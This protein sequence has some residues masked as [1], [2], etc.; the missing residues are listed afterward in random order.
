LRFY[1]KELMDFV[2]MMEN[3][4]E[5][6][7]IDHLFDHSQSQSHAHRHSSKAAA[8]P[9]V[10]I[11]WLDVCAEEPGLSRLCLAPR[12]VFEL[13]KEC[14]DE[15]L[16]VGVFVSDIAEVR[17]GASSHAFRRYTGRKSSPK[18]LKKFFTGALFRPDQCLA[19]VGSERSLSLQFA[20]APTDNHYRSARPFQSSGE[21]DRN[22]EREGV[23]T[24]GNVMDRSLFIDMLSLLVLQSLSPF[25][26]ALRNGLVRRPFR[27]VCPHPSVRPRYES[28]RARLNERVCREG[29]KVRQL[30]LTGIEVDEE[31]FSPALGALQI[32]HKRLQYLPDKRKLWIRCNDSLSPPLPLSPPPPVKSVSA[33]VTVS[34]QDLEE[35]TSFSDLSP[36][37]ETET[38]GERE[39]EGEIPLVSEPLSDSSDSSDSEGERHSESGSDSEGERDFDEQTDRESERD[40]SLSHSLSLSLS[41]THSLS[42]PNNWLG[43]THDVTT[44]DRLIDLDDVSQVR[45]GKVSL[46]S[47]DDAREDSL[48]VSIIATESILVLPVPTLSVRNNLVRRFQAFVALNRDDK[49]LDCD[50]PTLFAHPFQ[51]TASEREKE[52]ERLREKEREREPMSPI[53]KLDLGEGEIE[54]EKSDRKQRKRDKRREKKSS[55]SKSSLSHS[56]SLATPG[57]AI[58]TAVEGAVVRTPS[59]TSNTGQNHVL[60]HTK[61]LRSVSFIRK[62]SQS[63]KSGSMSL[64]LNDSFMALRGTSIGDF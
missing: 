29:E 2:I 46:S 5:V 1:S 55:S 57:A 7:N 60:S 43:V 3:G 27:R 39:G 50:A 17:R 32:T 25:E 12:S 18:L 23:A 34:A 59:N 38:G 44:H 22:G 15:R 45:P 48:Y 21:R 41:D 54:R 9:E 19:I 51:L 16:S 35:R 26:L 40:P 24:N 64:S 47:I 63:S 28:E 14:E 42:L 31:N 62:S 61:S 36:L 56:S 49:G 37:G 11:L 53:G 33:S 20:H 30:L 13:P 4:I 10:H 6:F 8:R 58:V 52:R